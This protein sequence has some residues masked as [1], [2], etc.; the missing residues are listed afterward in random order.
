MSNRPTVIGVTMNTIFASLHTH[1]LRLI[2]TAI[3][4]LAAA[5]AFAGDHGDTPTTATR[6]EFGIGAN[7][8]LESRSDIDVFRIDLQG[9]ATVDLS[10]SG[11]S[12][13]LGKLLDSDGGVIAEDD[14][15][16]KD[17]NFRMR[18][19]LEVGVYYLEVGGAVGAGDYRVLARIV[20]AG[21]DHGDTL[22]ASTPLQLNARIAGSMNPEGDTDVFRID[23]PVATGMRVYTRGSADTT[24]ELLDSS[25]TVMEEMDSGGDQD[26]FR[27]ETQVQPGIYYLRIT[28]RGTGAYGVLADVD[29]DGSCPSPVD[30]KPPSPTVTPPAPTVV[31]T[32]SRE[33]KA[34]WMWQARAGNAY[35]FDHQV[36]F[37]GD[38][39]W[40][41]SVRSSRDR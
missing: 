22:E 27:I 9:Q 24:G 16:G 26:N 12:D 34:S 20:P 2:V 17:F 31:V 11:S 18:E 29:D 28:A 23:I 36:R 15:G 13:T 21:D 7:G 32:S 5:A 41:V 37:K 6:L 40:V 19:T 10:S 14:D 38:A 35:A 8:V 25:G 1:G 30:A 4:L 3:F 39:E 33:I